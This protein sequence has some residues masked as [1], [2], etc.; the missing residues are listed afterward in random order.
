[1]LNQVPPF[2]ETTVLSCPAAHPVKHPMFI[3]QIPFVEAEVQIMG[4]FTWSVLYPPTSNY[5]TL[6]ATPV[7][8]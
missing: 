1:M 6:A 7:V 4:Q 5:Q 3:W 8:F 2:G